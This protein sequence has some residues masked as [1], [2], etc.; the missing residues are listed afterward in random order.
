[1]I[2]LRED[3]IGSLFL[4]IRFFQVFPGFKSRILIMRISVIWNQL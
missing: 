2:L 4:G 3:S 1:M